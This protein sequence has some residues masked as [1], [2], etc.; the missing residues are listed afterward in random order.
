V[1][2][3]DDRDP[4]RRY[5]GRVQTAQNAGTAADGSS[6]NP[7]LGIAFRHADNRSNTAKSRFISDS[8]LVDGTAAGKYC[9]QQYPTSTAR[10]TTAP[11]RMLPRD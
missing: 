2:R 7:Q 3:P 9:S 11:R 5:N 8:R 4:A 10:P 6:Q 1:P